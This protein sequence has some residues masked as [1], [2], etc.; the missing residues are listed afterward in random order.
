MCKATYEPAVCQGMEG[1]LAANP[2]CFVSLEYMPEALREQGFE[3]RKLL[4]WF[5]GRGYGAYTVMR[6]GEVHQLLV[7]SLPAGGWID[8]LF[9]R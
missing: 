7:D 2:D 1:T 3:P 8:L 9:R 5:A 4:D 6:D